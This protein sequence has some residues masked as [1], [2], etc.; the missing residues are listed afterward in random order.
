M[1]L[2][3]SLLA[4]I[5]APFSFLWSLFRCHYLTCFELLV[6]DTTPGAPRIKLVR[7]L[8]LKDNL[9]HIDD[10]LLILLPTHFELLITS[11]IL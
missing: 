10:H 5:A 3:A 1:A 7:G 9:V 4:R 2:R 11:N 6:R 8:I